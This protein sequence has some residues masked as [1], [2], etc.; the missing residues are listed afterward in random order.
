MY[1]KHNNYDFRFP[2][3]VCLYKYLNTDEPPFIRVFLY[4]CPGSYEGAVLIG[5]GLIECEGPYKNIACPFYIY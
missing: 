1:I 5:E 3:Y 2:C 4:P